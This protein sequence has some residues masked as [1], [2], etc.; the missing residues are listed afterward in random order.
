[1]GAVWLYLSMFSILSALY[2][3]ING[4]TSAEEENVSI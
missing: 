4:G 3:D 1:M 2:S